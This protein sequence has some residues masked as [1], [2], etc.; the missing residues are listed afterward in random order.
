MKMFG[1]HN[2][3]RMFNVLFMCRIIPLYAALIIYLSSD[4]LKRRPSKFGLGTGAYIRINTVF[5]MENGGYGHTA[6]PDIRPKPKR[7]KSKD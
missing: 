6:V 5:Q 4:F 7:S 1:R 2:C 3:L